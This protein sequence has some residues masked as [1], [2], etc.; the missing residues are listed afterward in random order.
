[1]AR[2]QIHD[3]YFHRAKAEGYAARSA[4]KLQQIQESK[5]LLRP[6]MRILDLGCAPG[7]WLQVAAEILGPQ[8][9]LIGLDL[10][11][12]KLAL[13]PTVTTFEGD[14]FATPPEALTGPAGGLFHAVLSDMAPNTSGHGDAERSDDLCRR[15]L[16][17][18]PDLLM[19]T[20]TLVM[21]VLEGAPFPQLLKDTR[22][23]FSA[24]KAFK[25]KASRDVSSEIFVIGQG[26]TRERDQ[27][28]KG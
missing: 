26:Y 12:V 17:L 20:G 5:R 18:L 23:I 1:M 25:P 19:P 4:Y 15:I 28:I 2:R 11:P 14:V 8:G 27:G 10:K 7:S 16:A 6:G 24:V 3:A 21:K 9:R 22:A 13:P